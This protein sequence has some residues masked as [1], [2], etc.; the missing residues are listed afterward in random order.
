MENV[1]VFLEDAA[2]K[3]VLIAF[4]DRKK[5]EIEHDFLREKTSI[6]LLPY[7]QAQLLA[8]TL[9]GDLDAYPA[10]FWK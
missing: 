4:Q 5:E 7:V 6:G 3:N 10:L 9:R 2:R 1:A 8:R